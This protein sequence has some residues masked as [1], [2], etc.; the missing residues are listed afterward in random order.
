M[1]YI[2][3]RDRLRSQL[4]RLGCNQN[5]KIRL[6]NCGDVILTNLNLPNRSKARTKLKDIMRQH[7]VVCPDTNYKR[8]NLDPKTIRCEGPFRFEE[9]DSGRIQ[10]VQVAG[11]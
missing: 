6:T 9:K 5:L 2:E 10:R 1:T 3:D 7:M 11:Y 4:V 8:W